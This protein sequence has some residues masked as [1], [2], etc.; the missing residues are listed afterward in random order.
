MRLLNKN[1][2]IY[3]KFYTAGKTNC[4]YFKIHCKGVMVHPAS[5]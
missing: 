1:Y 4:V 3:Y 2:F 5:I